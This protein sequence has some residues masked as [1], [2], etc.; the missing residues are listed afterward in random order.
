M[1]NYRFLVLIFGVLLLLTSC[2]TYRY[3]VGQGPQKG[4]EVTQKNHYLILG[5]VP[6]STS[7]P[8][9]MAGDAKDYE[10]KIQHTFVDGLLNSITMG[11]Y[12]PTTTT[13]TK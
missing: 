12:N 3:N 2:Y 8:V 7:D 1:Q 10:V 11:I 5:L 13:V 4:I 9:K 6:I